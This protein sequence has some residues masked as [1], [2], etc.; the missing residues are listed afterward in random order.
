MKRNPSLNTT[1]GLLAKME[2]S[3]VT[4]CF[5]LHVTIVRLKSSSVKSLYNMLK[6]RLMMRSQSSEN[7]NLA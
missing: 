3:Y 7:Y 4:T 6:G 2:S 5:G 1:N